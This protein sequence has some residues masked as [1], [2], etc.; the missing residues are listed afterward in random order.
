VV[1]SRLIVT[2]GEQEHRTG[3]DEGPAA[4]QGANQWL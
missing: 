2:V 1:I 4:D 3:E